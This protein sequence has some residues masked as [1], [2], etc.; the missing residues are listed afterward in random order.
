VNAKRTNKEQVAEAGRQAGLFLRAWLR[1][2][3]FSFSHARQ[4]ATIR[5]AQASS[6]ILSLSLMKLVE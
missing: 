1:I 3:H 5:A 4:R 6:P 2:R